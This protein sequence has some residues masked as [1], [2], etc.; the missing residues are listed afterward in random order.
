MAQKDAPQMRHGAPIQWG[1][2]PACG[3]LSFPDR[4]GA[5]KFA[6][7]KHPGEHMCAYRCDRDGMGDVWHIG[8]PPRGIVQGI[9]EWRVD[10]QKTAEIEAAVDAVRTIVENVVDSESCEVCWQTLTL[11]VKHVCNME[12]EENDE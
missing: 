11:G 4:K 10:T 9:E 6:R 3:K 5:K 8:H 2:C 1:R 7:R 12:T